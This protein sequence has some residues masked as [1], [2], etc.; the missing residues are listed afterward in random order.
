MRARLHGAREVRACNARTHARMHACTH[1]LAR[2]HARME[3]F[4][5]S[6]L[7]RTASA[8]PR[9]LAHG[10]QVKLRWGQLSEQE[11]VQAV[12]LA[13]QVVSAG[14]GRARG[15]GGSTCAKPLVSLRGGASNEAAVRACMHACTHADT[16]AHTRLPRRMPPALP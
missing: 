15:G 11:H 7:P 3:D 10:T 5:P 8:Q 2:A 14:S 4:D 12:Q 6:P 16:L 1:T 13:Y 9:L